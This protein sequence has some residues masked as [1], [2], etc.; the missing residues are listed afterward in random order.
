[1]AS[2]NIRTEACTTELNDCQDVLSKG[3]LSKAWNHKFP[4]EAVAYG[5][6]L[7]AAADVMERG[8]GPKRR[9]SRL[10]LIRY[11]AARRWRLWRNSL[12]VG[13]I[14]RIGRQLS[15]RKPSCHAQESGS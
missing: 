6:A 4:Q 5:K 13:S 10:A 12:Q 8:K 2:P 1:M 7:L 3:L 9:R 14:L 15:R 11:F